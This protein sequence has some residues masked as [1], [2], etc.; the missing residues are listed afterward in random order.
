VNHPPVI[1]IDG[2]S[3][4]GK[5]TMATMLANTLGWHF[6]D[7]GALYR[8]LALKVTLVGGGGAR[9]L[10][11]AM[12]VHNAINLNIYFQNHRSYLDDQDVTEAIRQEKVGLLASQIS[13]IPEVRQALLERQRA[14]AQAPG[15]V[16]DGRDMGS[17]VFPNADLKFYL[18]ASPKIRAQRR[19]QQ[20]KASGISVKFGDLLEDMQK[21][22]R[23]D[24]SRLVAPLV[25]PQEAIEIDTGLLSKEQVFEKILSEVKSRLRS[26]GGV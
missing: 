15:L 3:G 17:V 11:S 22:D 18:D 1:T 23:Q 10:E 26:N 19:E 24:K 21:R 14:F 25:V 6:L 9:P 13:A 7:S 8:L 20:L 2:P 4:V 5:G 12:L 16:T